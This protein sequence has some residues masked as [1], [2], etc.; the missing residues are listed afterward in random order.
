[1]VFEDLG[2]QLVKNIAHSVRAFRLRAGDDSGGA[3]VSRI[4]EI[5]APSDEPAAP[6]AVSELSAESEAA[7][8]RLVGK[9]RGRRRQRARN[10]S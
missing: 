10:L 1:M 6:V 7:G 3:A 2:E 4:Q 8:A 5:A 9:R